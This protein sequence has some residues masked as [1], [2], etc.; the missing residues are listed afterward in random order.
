MMQYP[1]SSVFFSVCATV[2][3][4]FERVCPCCCINYS[5][6]LPF[7]YAVKRIKYF[8]LAGSNKHCSVGCTV[9]SSMCVV[10]SMVLQWCLMLSSFNI[11]NIFIVMQPALIGML[12]CAIKPIH[13]VNVVI[14]S[15]TIFLEDK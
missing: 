8:F 13:R 14:F 15:I 12:L 6:D 7:L 4:H 5:L 1:I 2:E 9:V 11:V 3:S 10:L